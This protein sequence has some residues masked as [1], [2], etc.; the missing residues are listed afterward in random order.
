LT[1]VHRDFQRAS[2][3]YDSGEFVKNILAGSSPELVDRLAAEMIRLLA[4]PHLMTMDAKTLEICES[5][6]KFCHD[7]FHAYQDLALHE[8]ERS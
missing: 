7:L 5:W 6:D 8:V 2:T 1:Q 4:H 3:W